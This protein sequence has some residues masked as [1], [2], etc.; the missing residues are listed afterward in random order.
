[1]SEPEE[2]W[3]SYGKEIFIASGIYLLAIFL[4]FEAVMP[5]QRI[6]IPDFTSFA[7]LLFLPHGVRILTA[8]L[9]GWRSVIALFPGIFLAFVY[10]GGM[11][12]FEPS[13][14]TAIAITVLVAPGIFQAVY[15]LGWDIR[16]QADRMPC[17]PCIMVVGLIISLVGSVLINFALGSETASYFAY[18]IGDFFGLFFLMLIMMFIFRSLRR[19]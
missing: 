11:N 3:F 14:L 18:L 13:R 1:M 19:A 10:V 8:W 2:S 9:L 12:V 6:L 16:P 5:V 4:T 17:W 7:S 15:L